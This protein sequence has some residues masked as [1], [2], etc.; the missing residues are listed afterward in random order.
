MGAKTENESAHILIG[1]NVGTGGYWTVG[2]G[3]YGRA[4]ATSLFTPGQGWRALE[5][6]G[7]ASEL[8]PGHVHDLELRVI[9]QRVSLS[10][11]H[12][13]VLQCV[14]PSPL[15]GEQAG[16]YAWGMEEIEFSDFRLSADKP[17]IFLVMQFA[18]PYDDLY[19]EVV[20]PVCEELGFEALRGDDIFRPGVILQDIIQSIVSS[21]IVIAEITPV[22]ANVFYELG[23]AHALNK[24]TILLANRNT[25]KLPF[26]ISGYR[27]IFYDDSIRGKR[28]IEETLRKHLES[29]R[30]GFGPT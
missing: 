20:R 13:R 16:L 18:G 12:V 25:E 8:I 19:Q 2:L 26:D 30:R 10:V 22:N 29:V 14:L 4:Y 21:D 6:K 15:Q 11:D 17:Q 27:V 1:Y 5:M 24:P 28:D 7:A 3:G 9:G 23:Y